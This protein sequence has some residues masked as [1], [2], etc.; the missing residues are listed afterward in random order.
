MNSLINETSPYLLQHAHNPVDWYPW[1]D[2][3]LEKAKQEHKMLLI[4]IGYSACHWCH[5]MEKESFEDTAV[6][7]L[8]NKYFVC[9][10]VD[11]EERPDIDAIY[12]HAVQLMTGSGGW[13]LNCIALPDG[14]PVYG[15]TYFPK[16]QWINVLN[17]LNDVYANDYEKVLGY[18]VK[19]MSGIKQD[20]LMVAS[21]TSTKLSLNDVNL[22]IQNWKESFDVINGGPN[23]APKFPLPNNYQFLLKYGVL[24]SDKEV[25]KHVELTLD[26]IAMGGIYDQ[27]GGGF[28]RYSV[29][30]I[31]KVPHFEKMLYDNA[32]L[33]SLYC[34]G[35]SYF[36]K[37]MYKTIITQT[38]DFVERE[39][40]SPEGLFY[41]AL[42]ADS[43][44]VEG[45]FYV[46]AQ[47]ELQALLKDDFDFCTQL[48]NIN[49]SGYWEHGNYILLRSKTNKQL[50]EELAT[51]E[52][53][54]EQRVNKVNDILL[55]ARAK[56]VRPGLDD[57]QLTS[58][59]ALMIKG[60]CDAFIIT[61]NIKYIQHAEKAVN[62][63]LTKLVN[64]DGKVYR[65]YKNG[66]VTISGF[67]ED[68]SFLCEALIACYQCSGNSNYAFR[69]KQIAGYCLKF[70][71]SEQNGLFYF[72]PSDGEKL[73]SRKQETTD[74]VIPASNSSMAKALFCLG[75]L[76]GETNYLSISNGMLETMRVNFMNYGPG[77]SNYG[78]L[79]LNKIN[80]SYE[81]VVCGD[82]AT[83]LARQLQSNY[84]PHVM[85]IPALKDEEI[86]LVKN[87]YSG[88][89]N[90][91]YV[92]SSNGCLAPVKSI[93][94]VV[95]LVADTFK[96][97]E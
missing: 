51:S 27:I 93:D 81:V 56:R 37:P 57:K 46:W 13:P 60:L 26:K 8:M 39:L 91:F 47:E 17:S 50:A 67:L 19:L 10:K 42:D 34:E 23:R 94:E 89:V 84:L 49:S 97:E 96:T 64:S 65:S 62:F 15:G 71:Y 83:E 36:K 22:S 58:W 88:A 86:L 66:K 31:W 78:W 74:N 1:G 69:A 6:A 21:P 76:F 45:K 77:Y 41:S 2:I 32:Q 29:D 38:L 75:N 87:K 44:G 25:L 61:G 28:S 90:S 9:I 55:N 7:A 63:I 80:S 33:V 95:K 35:Y 11:R 92:C 85:V 30:G 79:M 53:E 68:Y 72:T 73:I 48:Y 24:Q 40:T 12:M 20:E 59:N 5:V 3:A 52:Q 54:I 70:F 18:A 82:N 4:S 14:R 43:E 16:P